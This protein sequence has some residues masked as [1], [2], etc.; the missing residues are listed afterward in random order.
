MLTLA[1]LREVVASL[2]KNRVQRPEWV[3]IHRAPKQCRI[4]F[5]YTMLEYPDPTPRQ[6]Y[7]FQRSYERYKRRPDAMAA[8]EWN[9]EFGSIESFRFITSRD[10]GFY[11]LRTYFSFDT[12][13]AMLRGI[14]I[15]AALASGLAKT[16]LPDLVVVV[17]HGC[18]GW[19]SYSSV[20]ILNS[21][22]MALIERGGDYAPNDVQ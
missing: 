6:E 3:R 22:W 8:Y 10:I 4:R 1:K 15:G 19:S 14:L 20:A 11:R 5:D 17:I 18:V 9:G 2:K 7:Y 21:G 16:S 13:K 12:L